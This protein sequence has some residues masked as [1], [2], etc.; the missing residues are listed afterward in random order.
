MSILRSLTPFGPRL[1][2]LALALA[3]AAGGAAPIGCSDPD[4]AILAGL[5]ETERARF[6]AGRRVATP[7]WTCHDLAGDVKKVGPSLVGLFGRRSGRAP[8]YAASPALL[9]AS[10]VWDERALTAFLRDPAGFVPGNGMVS[11]GVRDPRALS[12]LVFYLRHVTRPGARAGRDP[13]RD[14]GRGG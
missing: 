14:P 12:D 6:R 13:D 2:A 11:P 1:R 8:G 4:A 10:I 3:L 9:G 5:D 7:C